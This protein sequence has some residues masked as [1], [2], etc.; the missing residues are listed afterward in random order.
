MYISP[1]PRQDCLNVNR[2]EWACRRE[3]RGFPIWEWSVKLNSPSRKFKVINYVK[4]WTKNLNLS[5]LHKENCWKYHSTSGKQT[6]RGSYNERVVVYTR[7]FLTIRH[8]Q[9]CL[10]YTGYHGF[11][12][13]NSTSDGGHVMEQTT[14]ATNS[15]A[16]ETSVYQIIFFVILRYNS[17]WSQYDASYSLVQW[18]PRH[19]FVC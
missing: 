13:F 7:I 4:A 18:L 15:W 16:L 5:V 8:Y 2:I 12:F 6:R 3:S 14:K 11:L 17:S 1:I 19:F 9:L 10:D